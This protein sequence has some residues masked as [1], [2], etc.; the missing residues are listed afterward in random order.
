MS[1]TAWCAKPAASAMFLVGLSGGIASGKSTVVAVLRELG[2]AVIDA[3]VIAREV[4]QPRLKA[5]Q[6]IVRCFGPEILQESGE[7]DR[8]ALGNII[9]SHPEKRRLLNAITHPEIQKEMLKQVLKYFVLGKGDRGCWLS[10]CQR[11]ER[12]REGDRSRAE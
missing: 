7:I 9:F 4:V 11:G 2:C 10:P 8:E 12:D 3:D 1:Y 5:Y 6:Q